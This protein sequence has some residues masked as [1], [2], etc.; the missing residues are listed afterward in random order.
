MNDAQKEI[1][2]TAIARYQQSQATTN[3]LAAHV[4]EL[5]AIVVAGEAPAAI[6][7]PEEVEQED[8]DDS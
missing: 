2:Q 4:N 5:A 1:M 3:L 8:A 6:P 7:D